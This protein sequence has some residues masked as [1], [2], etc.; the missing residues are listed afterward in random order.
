MGRRFICLPAETRSKF[1][2]FDVYRC[3][4]NSSQRNALVCAAC[5]CY[6][7]ILPLTST[8]PLF[9]SNKR[10]RA[11]D[12]YRL[13]LAR[14]HSGAA[15]TSSRPQARVCNSVP[16]EGALDLIFKGLISSG[17]VL[18]RY[19]FRHA[20]ITLFNADVLPRLKLEPNVR[21]RA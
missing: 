7:G 21:C 15:L 14:Q 11:A 16:C 10:Q 2:L 12:L 5:V 20:T 1:L 9:K 18:E 13:D 8:L 4:G 19:Q 6:G 3:N 17:L